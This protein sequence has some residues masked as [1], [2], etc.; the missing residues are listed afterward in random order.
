[1]PSFELNL[2]TT[3]G[4]RHNVVDHGDLDSVR[5]DAEALAD[6]LMCH[7]YNGL[8]AFSPVV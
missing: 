5:D 1:M 4:Q 7:C 3:E 2:A 6:F 8:R